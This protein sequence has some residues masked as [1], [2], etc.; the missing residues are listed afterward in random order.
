MISGIQRPGLLL[1]IALG[2]SV[3]AFAGCGSFNPENP[4]GGR[5]ELAGM[6]VSVLREAADYAGGSGMVVRGG[7]TVFQWG[8]TG[9]RYDLKS[10]TKSIGSA[11]LGLAIQDRLIKL[12]DPVLSHYPPMGVAA[13]KNQ[14][15][16]WLGEITFLHLATQTAGFD[17]PGGYVPLL[18]R[19]GTKWAYSD[20]GPNWIADAL[21]YLYRRD[22]KELLFERVFAPLGISPADLTWRENRYRE[23]ELQGLPRRE[24]GSGV[25]ANVK[26]MVRFGE[27]YL[28]GGSWQGTQILP[29][30]FVAAIGRTPDFIKSLPVGND[31][32]QHYA[33]ASS[34]YG[35]LWWNNADGSL[36]GVP[37]DAFWSWGLYDSIILV[38]PSLDIVAAR[39]GD[40]IKSRAHKDGYRVLEHFFK[41]VVA[42][43]NFGAPVPN[44]RLITHAVWED[45][46]QVIRQADGSDN[47][48]ITWAD[49][50]RLY[51]AYGDGFGFEPKVDKKLSLGLARIEGTPPHAKGGNIRS[52]TGETYG[53]GP[54]G[55]KASGLIMV[56][57]KLWMAVRNIKDS[58]ELAQLWWSS[59][60]A[61]SW[62]RGE[63]LPE[64]FGCP[65]FL[66]FGKNYEDAR[67]RYVYIYS[68]KGPSAY[69][70]YDGVVLARV[71][72]ERIGTVAEFEYFQKMDENGHPVWTRRPEE[73]GPILEFKGA[74]F[75]MDVIYNRG[76]KRY[77]LLMAH[78]FSSSW[79]IYEAT[80]PWGPWYAVFHTPKWDLPGIHSYR[81]PAKWID[82]DGKTMFMVFSG[83][84]EEGYDAFCIRKLHL[85][86]AD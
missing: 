59:D 38:I 78:N 7:M 74:C 66:N 82:A 9:K 68:P 72:L 18:F 58:G 41:K 12:D 85:K 64:D 24:F 67:D 79:G 77:L 50:D 35:L 11:A 76:L 43:V 70:P 15:N 26:A 83:V 5:N 49:D 2:L 51:A 45:R 37:R 48:P 3:V 47:W 62:Q 32:N 34:H 25:S 8:D 46:S 13:D 40:S 52:E 53:H 20:S 39:A 28:N 84:Q 23:R 22:L 19:P 27:L 21:T 71:P 73:M 57:G 86:T 69:L 36:E 17:K 44:S 31:P 4:P 6:Q 33:G 54:K 80:E 30:E 61:K 55:M 65:T 63:M 75:R 60:Y 56:E 16:A 14:S 42:S 29:R 1:I 10:T 81:I